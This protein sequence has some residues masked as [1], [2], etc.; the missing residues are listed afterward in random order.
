MFQTVANKLAHGLFM[1]QNDRFI[2]VNKSFAE[3]SGYEQDEILTMHFTEFIYPEDL[4][5]FLQLVSRFKTGEI[6]QYE[7]EIRGVKKDG[8]VIDISLGTK[9][10]QY[11][12]KPASIGSLMD[13]SDRKK[14]ELELKESR[15]RYKNL[16]ENAPVGIVVHQKGIIQYANAMACKL[17][18]ANTPNELIGQ[19][20]TRLI[21][22]QYEE[23][24][25][26]R[27]HTVQN[28]GVTATP[29]YQRLHRMDGSEIDVA[30]SSIPIQLNGELAIE[31][32]FWDITE[33]KKEE[34]L[35]RFRAY[36]DILTDLPNYQ[37]FQVDFEEEFIGDQQLTIL[38]L[39]LN[40]LKEINDVHG[41]QAG[42]LV[43]IK[44]GGRLSG[45]MAKKGLVYRMDGYRFSIVLPG[46]VEDIELHALAEEIN[47]IISQ[48]IYMTN[49]TAQI[50]VNIGVVYYPQDGGEINLI[51][52]H[53]DLAMNHAKVA[54]S[55]YEKYDG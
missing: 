21:H 40:G 34:E 16:V 47:R 8:T 23:I 55:L 33:K 53:A 19:P 26:E 15:N 27:I 51:L 9:R 37:K 2:W 25:S 38:Y 29:L 4:N 17:L 13:I 48:P 31:S 36:H 46:V 22:R 45:A 14:M 10:V 41:R 24:V 43:L 44:V 35:I 3:I 32:M 5:E 1:M 12:D 30:T 50:S 6:E 20:I 28:L 54:K 49:S 52:H 11:E 42:D 18:G 39:N 7:I